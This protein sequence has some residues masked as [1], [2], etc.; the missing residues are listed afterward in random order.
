MVLIVLLVAAAVFVIL[1]VVMASVAWLIASLIA[2]VLAAGLLIRSYVNVKQ[3]R[4]GS[5]DGAAKAD[6]SAAAPAAATSSGM[7]SGGPVYPAS[8]APAGDPSDPDVLVIDGMPD[9]HEAECSRLSGIEGVAAIPLSQALEDGFSPCPRCSPPTELPA[10]VEPA[11]VVASAARADVW[12][13]DGHPEYHEL[14]CS[15]LVGLEGEA[16]PFAQAVE[17]G[18]VPCSVCE[19]ITAAPDAVPVAASGGGPVSL[20]KAAAAPELQLVWVA[21]G[22]P[23]YHVEMCGELDGVES[24]PVPY[25]QAVGDGFQP[26][27]VCNPDAVFAAAALPAPAAAGAGPHQVWVVDGFPEF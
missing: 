26:C 17:D 24:E 15:R 11:P 18:F 23:E 16:I 20:A 9:Y 7:P 25:E 10:V 5:V 1:G 2:S 21:D 27:V 8:A 13:A 3:R 19:P 6:R 22:F 14:G 12:V 4:S